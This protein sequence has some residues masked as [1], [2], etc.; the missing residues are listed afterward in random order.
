MTT[1]MGEVDVCSGGKR[2]IRNGRG[3]KYRPM[4]NLRA[5]PQNNHE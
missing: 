2:Y 4:I 5:D 1:V 3:A